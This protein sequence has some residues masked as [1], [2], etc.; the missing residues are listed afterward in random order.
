MPLANA[1]LASVSTEFATAVPA[2]PMPAARKIVAAA[3]AFSVP[4]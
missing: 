1:I 3:T 4:A 2:R